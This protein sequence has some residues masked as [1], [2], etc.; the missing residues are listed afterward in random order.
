MT[1]VFDFSQNCYSIFH[2]KFC[3]LVADIDILNA[4]SDVCDLIIADF[5]TIF[6]NSNNETTM[7][8]YLMF[9]FELIR[10]IKLSLC[11]LINTLLKSFRHCCRRVFI[12]E[13]HSVTNT[14]Q[15]LIQ[16]SERIKWLS[17]FVVLIVFHVDESW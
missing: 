12:S 7:M 9:V 15:R 3:K 16:N 17:S 5:K 13:H 6:W 10:H 14:M 1:D 8:S 4:I 2:V 11:Q